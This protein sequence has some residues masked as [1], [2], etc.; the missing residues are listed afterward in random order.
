MLKKEQILKNL[1]TEWNENNNRYA[2][3]GFIEYM[4]DYCRENFEDGY[5]VNEN[6]E[7]EYIVDWVL[8]NIDL[9]R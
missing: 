3:D 9:S 8:H 4:E 7:I 1:Q 2:E 5:L 6:G